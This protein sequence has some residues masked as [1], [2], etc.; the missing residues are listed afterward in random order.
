MGRTTRMADVKLSK[1]CNVK[2]RSGRTRPA[3]LYKGKKESNWNRT[4]KEEVGRRKKENLRSQKA[5]LLLKCGRRV[6]EEKTGRDGGGG[7]KRDF[8]IKRRQWSLERESQM[9]L[10]SA[11]SSKCKGS[12]VI[13]VP[14]SRYHCNQHKGG[15]TAGNGEGGP[16]SLVPRRFL[17]SLARPQ[18]L[19][20][21]SPWVRLA[22]SH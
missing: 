13:R 10:C 1:V 4:K 17:P 2:K 6:E 19:G 11:T 16:A 21:P 14:R 18:V 5:A 3:Q 15:Q 12:T 20:P 8:V 7:K 9:D 22:P